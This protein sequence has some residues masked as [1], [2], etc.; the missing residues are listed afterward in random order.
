MPTYGPH[1]RASS[2]WCARGVG[3][4]HQTNCAWLRVA[5]GARR[6][7]MQILPHSRISHHD[8]HLFTRRCSEHPRS[9]WATRHDVINQEL[10]ANCC[11]LLGA[12]EDRDRSA[13]RRGSGLL[14]SAA[15]HRRSGRGGLSGHT[16]GRR[17]HRPRRPPP[18]VPAALFP[19]PGR[20]GRN[21]LR[22]G[23]MSLPSACAARTA[24]DAE[25][26]PRDS[27]ARTGHLRRRRPRAARP[28]RAAGRPGCD[29]LLAPLAVGLCATDLELLDG[30][31]VYLRD[32]PHAAAPGARARVG[33][34]GGGPRR[35]GQRVRRG[36]VVGGVQHRLRRL[37]RVR[38]GRLPRVPAAA[39][40]RR[41]EPRRRSRPAAALPRPQRP[42]RAAGR[43]RG[44][45]PL[46]RADGGRAAGRSTLRRRVP[47]ARARRGRW[48]PRLACRCGL[49]RPPGRRGRRPG[50]QCRSHGRL[51]ALGVRAA[52][53]EEVFDVVLEASG[54]R[55]AAALDRL[56]L[57]RA[58]GGDRPDRGGVGASGPGPGRGERPGGPG[59]PL[60]SPD[61]W[62]QALELLGRGRV[63]PSALVTHRYPLEAV[64]EAVATMRDRAPGTGK[65]LVLP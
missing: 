34:P 21:C 12:A 19:A 2:G 10:E 25:P 58:P 47:L 36:D 38:L 29:L 17:A 54:S 9:A 18:P 37:P 52:E 62:P 20:R 53:A 30:S 15:D 1:Q 4:L 7:A 55:V 40:D 24:H 43:G 59:V 46:R 23:A 11:S 45:R 44:G 5:R 48:H 6:V 63:R 27:D 65:V 13:V 35:A 57:Q 42:R 61:V 41:N 31:M 33:G 51:A 64:G 60:G 14:R 39:G 56:G 22:A 32:G 8:R 28:R 3:A 26:R 16:T 50:A 49:P